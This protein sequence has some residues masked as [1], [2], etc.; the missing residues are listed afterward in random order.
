M[1][2][3]N[4]PLS[5]PFTL[6][7]VGS[8]LLLSSLLNY[9]SIPFG[10]DLSNKP[11]L[12]EPISKIID[13][14]ATPM[15]GLALI[16]TAYWLDRMADTG[17]RSKVLR[18]GATVY[19][20]ILGVLFLGLA[21]VHINN[22]GIVEGKAITG[23]EEQA[24]NA[25]GQVAQQVEQR[26]LQL[27]QLAGDP[28]KID[29]QLKQFNDAI[30]NKQVPEDQIPQ[31]QQLVKDLQEIKG[32]PGA[33]KEKAQKSREELLNQVRSKK[34]AEI[35]R[36]K[37]EMGKSKFRTGLSGILFSG[38]YLVMTWLG[39][40]EMGILGGGNKAPRRAPAK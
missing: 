7:L 21:L 19:A 32:N 11:S 35:S 40:S 18:F 25:E 37:G 24:K 2:A 13:S 16:S 34:E 27:A 10:L 9:L 20:A 8:I 23:I 22:A 29:E 33:L 4:T 15:V 14:G 36:I 26:E 5:A 28:K 1:K 3:T 6:K 31:L 17:A 12:I 38:G 39:L 30:A